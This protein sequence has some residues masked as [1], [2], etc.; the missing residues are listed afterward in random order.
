MAKEKTLSDLFHDTLRDIYFAEKQILKALPKMQR[1]ATNEQLQNAFEKHKEQ[2]E[3][4]VARLEQVFEIIGKS[5][6]GKTCEAIKGIIDEGEEI[7]DEYK[8]TAAL[9]A[10]LISAAQAVEHYEMTRY[11]TLRRWAQELGMP[12]AVKLLDATLKEE[13]QTDKD[14]TSLAEKTVNQAAQTAKAA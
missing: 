12:D 13:S 14:L 10:G 8:G 4:H 3:E 1:A 5:A 9:D 11:G 2:T 6:R 7:I